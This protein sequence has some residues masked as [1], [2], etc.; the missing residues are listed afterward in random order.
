MPQN[1]ISELAKEFLS[2]NESGDV[3]DIVTYV[4]APWGLNITLLPVQRF[5]LKCFYGLPLNKVERNIKVPDLINEHVLYEF[6]ETD[7]LRWLYAEGRCN[8]EVTEGKIFQE[9]VLAI[10]RRGTK[11]RDKNDRIATTEGSITFGE[12]CDRLAK[13]EKVGVGTYDPKT[14]RK[15]VV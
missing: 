8:T 7:F 6:S 4:E 15:S 5:I 11:C 1:L 2:G 12:L 3:A 14:D 9:L 10:G 13:G